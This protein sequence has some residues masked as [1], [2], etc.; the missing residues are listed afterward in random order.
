[1][2]WLAHAVMLAHGWR[3]AALMII[4]GAVAGLSVPPFF[5][6]PAVFISLPI[7]VWALDGAEPAH[8]RWLSWLFGPAFRIG[9][10]FGWGYF[11]VAFHWLGTAFFVDGGLMLVV[12][13]FAIAALAALIALFWG[14]ASALAHRM[15]SH[16][17][18]RIVTLASWLTVAEFA[19]GHV[20]SGFPF[21]LLGYALTGTPELMQGAALVGVYG[22]TFLVALLG[23]S[24][25]MVWP[26]DDRPLTRRLFPVFAG[27]GIIAA[28]LGY[29]NVRLA[30]GPVPQL[31]QTARLV[32]PMV[33]EHAD[34]ADVDPPAIIDRLIG[35]SQ[36]GGLE[37]IDLVVW[38]ESALPFYLETY[39]EALARIARLLPES[40]VLL[41]GAPRLD[42]VA[43]MPPFNALLAIDGAGEVISS[44]DKAHLVPFGEFLPFG[45]IWSRFGLRQFV[46]GAEGWQHGDARQRL[47]Q[48]ADLPPLLALICYEILFSGDLGD[49]ERAAVLLN[50]TNDA[51]FD[52]SIGPAQH[53]H[54]ARLRSV[55]EGIGLVRVAN[56]GLTF[57]ADAYGRVVAELEPRQPGMI[58][59]AL[60]G[61][62]EPTPFSRWRHWP[63]LAAI[64]IGLLAGLAAH[65]R[66]TRK[67]PA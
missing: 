33:L 36:S 38:P 46:P 3:R 39:P 21:D 8:R 19:R 24:P 59:V 43:G 41:A 40:T 14:F 48:L 25:A 51:W 15:W 61:R 7:W 47:M 63:L 54:H 31:A 16:G 18:W 35:L 1:M 10:M 52:S 57:V 66:R 49:T 62:I 65:R 28:L 55:E 22:L 5:I 64:A 44:Y 11:L 2:T 29:G 67:E 50:V 9:F 56:T 30:E 58:D 20:L 53:A 27:L 13:P 23:M 6:L 37:G 26:A 42:F 45:E 4:A 12:M 17:A 60:P 34:W 32:Q